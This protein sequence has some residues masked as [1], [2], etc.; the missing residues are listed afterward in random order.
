MLL[1]QSSNLSEGADSVSGQLRRD[2][3]F[4]FSGVTNCGRVWRKVLESDAGSVRVTPAFLP[5]CLLAVGSA[6]Y[7]CVPRLS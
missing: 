1:P 2:K 6:I 7:R 4:P 3:E 5:A